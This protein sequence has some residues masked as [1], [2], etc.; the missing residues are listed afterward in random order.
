MNKNLKIAIFSF[1]VIGLA[2]ATA[3]SAH[4]GVENN[5]QENLGQFNNSNIE[6]REDRIRTMHANL[7]EEDLA[8]MSQMHDLMIS[9]EFDEALEIKEELGIGQKMGRNQGQRM[10]HRNRGMMSGFVDE[11]NNSICDNMENIDVN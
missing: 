11:N 5:N 7:S 8:K 4:Q 10:G 1:L 6:D 3:V 2:T 9:G